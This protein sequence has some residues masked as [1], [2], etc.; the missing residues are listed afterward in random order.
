MRIHFNVSLDKRFFGIAACF[1][2]GYSKQ[3]PVLAPEILVLMG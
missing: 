3:K 2:H 1:F